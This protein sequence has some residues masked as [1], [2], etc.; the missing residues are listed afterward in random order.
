MSNKLKVVGAK[1]LDRNPSLRRLTSVPVEEPPHTIPDPSWD[2]CGLDLVEVLQEPGF[3]DCLNFP[4]PHEH[5][6][7]L[8]NL[9]SRQG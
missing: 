8:M 9:V 5:G 1:A 4:E 7:T 2:T 3:G 6:A